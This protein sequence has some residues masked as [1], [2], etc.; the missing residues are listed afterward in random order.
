MKT[1]DKEYIDYSHQDAP[2][3]LDQVLTYFFL[4]EN[5][6]RTYSLPKKHFDNIKNSNTFANARRYFTIITGTNLVTNK[7]V[8]SYR[9]NQGTRYLLRK[10]YHQLIERMARKDKREMLRTSHSSP[11]Q[12]QSSSSSQ[13][14]SPFVEYLENQNYDDNS[15]SD[16]SNSVSK[17][18]QP[19]VNK[20]P[21]IAHKQNNDDTNNLSDDDST[22]NTQITKLANDVETEMNNAM[23]AVTE[24]K[25]HDLIPDEDKMTTIIQNVF[26]SELSTI[27]K[28]LEHKEI[29][30][31]KEIKKSKTL[32]QTLRENIESFNKIHKEVTMNTEKLTNK[33]SYVT[34]VIEEL[35]Q[36]MDDLKGDIVSESNIMKQID[37]KFKRLHH[38]NKIDNDD[39]TTTSKSLIQESHEK[40]TRRISRLKDK[41]NTHF[42]QQELDY[43][44]LTDRVQRLER[45]FANLHQSDTIKKR[46][47]YSSDNSKSSSDK[48]THRPTSYPTYNTPPQHSYKNTYYRGPNLDYLRKN[49]N[50]TCSAQNQI[51][52][53]YIKF[54]LALEPGGIHIIPIDQIT[55]HRSLAQDKPGI[56]TNDQRLQSNA[57][58]TLLSN[59]KIIPSDFTMAQ[60][61]I[62]GFASTMDG[63][64]ALRAMLKL[65]HPTL[66]KKRPSNTPPVLSESN[67]IHAYEQNLR[68]YYLLHKLFSD[69]EYAPIEKAKQFLQGIDDGQYNDAVQRVQHQLDTIETLNVP[70]HE[71]YDIENIAS[72]IINISGEY[73]NTKTIVNTMNPSTQRYHHRKQFPYNPNRKSDNF[74][75][76]NQ[77]YRSEKFDKSQCYACKSFGHT[78]THCKLLPRVLAVMQFKSKYSDKCHTI[79]NQHI[80]NNTVDSKR[81]FVKTLQNMEILSIDDDCDAYLEHDIIIN[82]ITDNGFVDRD[83]LSDDE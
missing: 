1:Q 71:D 9:T 3:I 10:D 64:G 5:N 73:D 56:T 37:A 60:N 43:D 30:L 7:I 65:T 34:R 54:R 53:F 67:D 19:I 48:S 49:V 24:D 52:E 58:F 45:D 2:N 44:L 41:S 59:E 38:Q 72:T 81:T 46:L 17:T 35:R 33:Y 57:L 4:D 70:L 68:N 28:R 78:V 11:K 26:K 13:Q 55:K 47:S 69:T 6:T 36:D 62:L 23:N 21:S 80:R 31:D 66:S 14:K 25:Q 39:Q 83:F 79:L 82:T 61:C 51:L 75:T 29:A 32:N 8:S 40:L 76:P 18:D 22:I 15:S 20:T 16:E 12:Q 42:E 50:I 27:M 77:K 74:R 63:F